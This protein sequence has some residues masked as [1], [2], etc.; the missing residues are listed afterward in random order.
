MLGSVLGWL[1]GATISSEPLYP[2]FG[3]ITGA[4]IGLFAALPWLPR[5]EN[6]TLPS[7]FMD[8]G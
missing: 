2:F 7:D 3:A 8:W 5:S 4:F 1:A 6:T